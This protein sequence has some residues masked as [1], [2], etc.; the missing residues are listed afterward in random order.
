MQ[1]KFNVNAEAEL[2]Y[3]GKIPNIHASKATYM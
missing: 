3:V 2:S 1:N